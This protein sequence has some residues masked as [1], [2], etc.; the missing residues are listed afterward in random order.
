MG[1]TVSDFSNSYFCIQSATITI[2]YPHGGETLIK[3]QNYTIT[4]ASSNVTGNVQ[5]DL[6]KGGSFYQQ[7]A[8]SDPNDGSY[9]F[10][11]PS[12]FSDGN[13]YKI[14]ISAMGGSV[15]DF[16]D[17][18]FTIS[19]P[20][21]PSL[22]SPTNNSSIT[23]SDITFQWS[24]V[25]GA[26]SYE[27]L[28]DNNSG[29]GSPELNETGLTST[30]R[31]ITNHISD[32]VYYWK[33]RAKFADGSY[34]QWASPWQFTYNLPVNPNAVWV[35][36]FR[37]YKYDS[38]NNTRDHFYTTNSTERD[39]AVNTMS[40]SDEG[41]E[42]YIS[43]RNFTGGLPLYRLYRSDVNS[44]FYTT[45]VT[46]KDDMIATGGYS[47]EGIQ[48]FVNQNTADGLVSLHR[49]KQP[50]GTPY[51]YFLS[52]KSSEYNTVLS[53]G[54]TET[55]PNGIGYVQPFDARDPNAHGRPQANY[56]EVDLGS[57]AL[58]GLNSL[59]LVMKGKGFPLIFSHYYNSFDMNHYPY[60]M[61]P[62]WGHSLES[63]IDED[64]DGN[65]FVNWGNGSISYFQKTGPGVSDYIDKSGNHDQL[66]LIDDGMNYGYDLKKKNQ[67]VYKY[68]E[69]SVNPW[70]GTPQPLWF[71]QNNSRILLFET[72]DWKV[73]KLTFN[74]EAAYGT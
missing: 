52:S 13:D 67:T 69:Y 12:S 47:Y 65:I 14:G 56:G 17:N 3:G 33:V 8:A 11:P 4:W 9:P 15:S 35:P 34:T 22:I 72:S 2:T 10:N 28:V 71:L 68:R 20:V 57:G 41:V 60:P 50:S 29:F 18:F 26:D 6:Y 62:G 42:C 24:P 7:L 74:R 48:G 16:S 64:I 31:T 37:L 61:G 49:L 66:T 36:L 45:S 19:K 54:Y 39:N 51:H 70:P 53:A 1:G 58:R 25:S 32:N 38:V 44:H 27:I 63:S 59:D 73:N 30:T 40:Y 55:Y 5:I 46:E 23:N 43:D 21:G